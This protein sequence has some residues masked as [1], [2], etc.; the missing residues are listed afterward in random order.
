MYA[1]TQVIAAAGGDSKG[2][3][4]AHRDGANEEVGG[5]GVASPHR[6]AR[7]DTVGAEE[8]ALQVSNLPATVEGEAAAGRGG[9]GHGCSVCKGREASLKGAVT[10]LTRVT[11]EKEELRVKVLELEK[12]A[13]QLHEAL[14]R[15]SSQLQ[16]Y[17]EKEE[18]LEVR[19][20]EQKQK[21][22]VLGGEHVSSVLM[23]VC[24]L[25]QK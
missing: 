24:A 14:A 15:K 13:A 3:D 18:K 4:A 22:G 19:I 21:I 9:A 10:R 5:S 8:E 17:V 12:S 11:E 1:F 6:E 25:L 23:G 20:E 16:Q 7:G 2:T